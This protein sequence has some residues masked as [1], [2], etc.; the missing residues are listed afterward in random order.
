MTLGA[1]GDAL[2]TRAGDLMEGR[3]VGRR[4]TAH[5]LI[6]AGHVVRPEVGA[7]GLPRARVLSGEAGVFEAFRGQLNDEQRAIRYRLVNLAL[8]AVDWPIQQRGRLAAMAAE[9]DEGFAAALREVDAERAREPK[10]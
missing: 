4:D 5:L 10:Q 8:D 2:M 7:P 1:L 9:S 3:R 6:S